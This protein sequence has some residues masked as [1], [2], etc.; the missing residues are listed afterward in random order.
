MCWKRVCECVCVDDFKVMP[1]IIE[2]A[3]QLFKMKSWSLL[4]LFLVFCFVFILFSITVNETTTTIRLLQQICCCY[5]C[6]A[7]NNDADGDDEDGHLAHLS[8]QPLDNQIYLLETRKITNH[9][10]PTRNMSCNTWSAVLIRVQI[11]NRSLPTVS[12]DSSI[13]KVFFCHSCTS[14]MRA[15][16]SCCCRLPHTLK[17]HLKN[18]VKSRGGWDDCLYYFFSFFAFWVFAI[19]SVQ[20]EFYSDI[21]VIIMII[22]PLT[23]WRSQIRGSVCKW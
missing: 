19:A 20:F 18:Y 10:R 21:I 9:R 15:K 13:G 2:F 17:L 16:S 11:L 5:G 6:F 8:L 22:T 12:G 7:G 14:R 3:K 1:T 4:D 23:E